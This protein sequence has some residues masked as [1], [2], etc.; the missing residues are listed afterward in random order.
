M[1]T[2]RKIKKISLIGL[3]AMGSFFAPR[4][5]MASGLLQTESGKRDLRQKVLRLMV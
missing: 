3:G 1:N 4:L 2:E 5:E